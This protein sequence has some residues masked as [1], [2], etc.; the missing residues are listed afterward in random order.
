MNGGFD[1]QLHF[2]ADI[3][4]ITVM[5]RQ[6]SSMSTNSSDTLSGFP[7]ELLIRIFACLQVA[8]LLS[9]QHTCRRFYDII[10]DSASLQYFLHTEINLLEDHLVPPDF[11]LHDRVALLKRHETA[12][13][14]LELN[15][16]SQFVTPQESHDVL[17]CD[18]VLQD[19]YLIY[20]AVLTARYGYMDLYSSSARS[21]AEASWTHIAL[22]AIDPLLDIVFAVDQNLAVAI[23]RQNVFPE[24]A[25]LEF[26][27]GAPHPLSLVPTVAL[28][29][30]GEPE[31]KVF[32]DYLLLTSNCASCGWSA[33]SVVSWK[34]GT[35]SRLD[36][37]IGRLEV[38]VIDPDNSLIALMRSATNSIH[39]YELQSVSAQ[40]RLHNLCIL[41]FP[42]SVYTNS[43]SVFM[44]TTEWIPTSK[45]QDRM[46]SQASR[47]RAFPFRSYRAGSIGLLLNFEA[48]NNGDK[49]YEMF[50]SVEALL[51]VV[52][53]GVSHVRWA[54]WGPTSTRIF[55]LGED[56]TRPAGPF[57]IT[58]NAPLVIRDYN[59]L[60]AQHMKM[61]N[62]SM[63]S[64]QPN[65]GPYLGP[66]STKL[67]GKH[68]QGG[69]ISTHL[70]FREFVAGGLSL[71]SVDQV[72]ADREWFVVISDV[73]RTSGG[74][75]TSITVYHVG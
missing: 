53:S 44:D 24:A 66:P 38:V 61:T 36:V 63:P 59:C 13:N 74:K 57:W 43:P 39:I 48:L 1:T 27:T 7:T 8:D 3:P 31:A 30:Q 72:V 46:G 64:N 56:I 22:T 68:W 5:S 50:V 21:N 26:T 2:N 37:V 12:W 28:M 67:F 55:P 52:H 34:I 71:T 32:G 35:Y 54:D 17:F 49:W 14:Y 10:S 9:I 19:G 51:S 11:S 6:L 16:F 41:R 75:P 33:F 69:E 23:S 60:R 62:N 40:P 4:G 70:P 65:P 73:V 29:L 42:G 25:F 58:S 47:G 20:N 18:Y 15:K 45:L